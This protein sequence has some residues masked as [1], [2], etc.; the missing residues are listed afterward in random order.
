[1]AVLA[2]ALQVL[3]PAWALLG[4]AS[5]A[6]PVPRAQELMN[7]KH[8]KMCY[9]QLWRADR[10]VTWG[11]SNLTGRV[12]EPNFYQFHSDL[13]S[14]KALTISE[15]K[16]V[17]SYPHQNRITNISNL[18]SSAL[19][20]ME[21]GNF[22]LNWTHDVLRNLKTKQCT[23][24]DPQYPMVNPVQAYLVGVNYAQQL[25]LSH[26]VSNTC[27]ALTIAQKIEGGTL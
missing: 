14:N 16:H 2:W 18:H 21:I 10:A 12:Q 25:V 17:E 20:N 3:G 8:M 24:E 5:V 19:F 26:E 7:G 15:D 11:A 27:S 1:M 22:S 4:A 23:A 13:K 6:P 9:A